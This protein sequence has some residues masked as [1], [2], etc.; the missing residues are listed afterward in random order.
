[1]EISCQNIWKR[2]SRKWILKALDFDIHSGECIGIQGPNGSGKSTLLQIL[3][4]YLSPTRGQVIYR[5]GD[6]EIGRDNIYRHIAISA[7]Y[8]DIDE[9]MTI[10]EIFHHYRQFKGLTVADL[11][12][13]MSLSLFEASSQQV[14]YFSSGMKQRLSLTLALASDVPFLVFDEPTA[15]LDPVHKDWFYTNLDAVK[16]GDKTIILATN[17]I[18][19]LEVC[20]RILTV[21][22][23]FGPEIQ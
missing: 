5:L 7:A 14:R 11:G 1:M 3:S 22:P 12:Q 15:F 20:D 16:K 23:Q 9:E 17:D 19:D 8:T 21:H 13:L 2:Y 6:T 18:A 4:G 10:G